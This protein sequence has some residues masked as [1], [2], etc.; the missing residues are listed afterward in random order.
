MKAL[1]LRLL[2]CAR[3]V[4]SSLPEHARPWGMNDEFANDFTMFLPLVIARLFTRQGSPQTP[5]DAC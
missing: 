4:K 3:G 2:A 5:P 1:L